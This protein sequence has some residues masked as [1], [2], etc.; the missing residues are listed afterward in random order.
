MELHAMHGVFFVHETHDLAFFGPCG[1]F[2]AIGQ[3]ITFDDERV[4]TRGLEGAGYSGEDA[5]SR[6]MDG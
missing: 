1:D 5:F 2:K 4:I 3:S 6:V